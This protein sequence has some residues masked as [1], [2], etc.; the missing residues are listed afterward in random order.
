MAACDCG[1]MAGASCRPSVDYLFRSVAAAYGAEALGI[2]MT[3]MGDDGADGCQL[4]KQN[5]ATIL[6]QDEASC[7]VYGMPR[8]IVERGLAD[9]VCSLTAISATISEYVAGERLCT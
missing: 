9:G 5:G 8:Q 7:V 6:A 2:I 3:G 1:L 4:L